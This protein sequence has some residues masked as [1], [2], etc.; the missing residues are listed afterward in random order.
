[1]HVW[2]GGRWGERG[3]GPL[4]AADCFT[5]YRDL[6]L[7]LTLSSHS[8]NVTLFTSLIWL[9]TTHY[10]AFT[11]ILD[12]TKFWFY[13]TRINWW[14]IIMISSLRGT[15]RLWCAIF[16]LKSV[17]V[18]AIGNG[19]LLIQWTVFVYPCIL[20]VRFCTNGFPSHNFFLVLFIMTAARDEFDK[21][22]SQNIKTKDVF[23]H[24]LSFFFIV[25][26]DVQFVVVSGLAADIVKYNFAEFKSF[27][28]RLNIPV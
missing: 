14:H 22:N 18:S 19:D 9:F 1:M 6:E 2:E 13:G 5:L 16:T 24:W 27:F 28:K 10:K 12:R 4:L 17:T 7:S 15:S 3:C 8:A 20:Y 21:L 23:K 11:C 25:L 26:S